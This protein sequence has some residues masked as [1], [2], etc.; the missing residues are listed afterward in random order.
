MFF[1]SRCA[2]CRACVSACPT[3]TA[4]NCTACG[5]CVE[6]C[7]YG[8]REMSGR[9]M[10]VDE[11]MSGILHDRVFYD[12][13]AGGVT[14]SGGEPLMQ[15][16][17]LKALLL[18]C[19]EEGL[20]TTV[21]TS[22]FGDW[23]HLEAIVPS[24]DLFLYDVKLMD[25]DRH[26]R[27][28]G[29]SNRLILDNLRRLSSLAS[30]VSGTPLIVARIPLVPGINDDEANMRS[31]GEF[32]QGCGVRK[33]SVLPYHSL[34]SQKYRRLGLEYK[35]DATEPPSQEEIDRAAATLGSY[36][37]AATAGR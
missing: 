6:A 24:V 7:V 4:G 17:F 19:R 28:V 32:L 3:G 1:E 31:T 16:E 2:A 11:V 5:R 14:F 26:L 30:P 12:Q 8:A 35:M 9:E 18:R 22:G 37:L 23:A 15:P 29:A 36:G 10:T 13:S 27:Y 25:D 20:R 34:G 33:V 21:D